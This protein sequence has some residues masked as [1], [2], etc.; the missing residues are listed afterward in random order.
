[1]T[2]LFTAHLDETHQHQLTERFP[3]Q[4]FIFREKVDS[5]HDHLADAK[6]IVT[7]G[8]DVT[9]DMIHQAEGL[10]WIMVLSA[11]VDELPLNLIEE[12]GIRVTNV[13][14]IH[15]IP[16]AEYA[17][18]TMLY[19]CRKEETLTRNYLNKE[20][21]QTL[22][23]TE[24]NDKTMLVVGAGSIGQEIAR[25]G[26]AF[27]M[28]T[29]G[30]SRSGSPVEHFD[31]IKTIDAL[32][33]MLPRA[34]FVVSVLPSTPE[35]EDRYTMREFK[36]MKPSAVFFNIGRG[37]AVIE[38][39]LLEAVQE[40]EIAH[41]ILDVFREEPLPKDNPFW[42]EENVTITPHVAAKTVNYVPR[43]MAIFEENLST[44]IDGKTDY[45]NE[46]DVRRGY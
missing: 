24:L 27:R 22:P 33:D 2:I 42:E 40:G 11:G 4:T 32:D 35:T 31:E 6:V 14:G 13:R 16:M 9:E 12:K 5:I 23:F 29:L 15:R 30:L 18:S 19:V 45:V 1:M 28:T 43:A 41:A 34:D 17:I 39:D 44:Y 8:A 21:D 46:I 37:D 7:Y 20:W 38:E 36:L 10:E 3:S 25:L 26:Q